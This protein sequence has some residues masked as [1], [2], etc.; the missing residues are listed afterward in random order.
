VLGS[1]PGPQNLRS[2]ARMQPGHV[3][4]LSIGGGRFPVALPVIY[5]LRSPVLAEHL[6]GRDEPDG[7]R[8]ELM[9][10]FGEPSS[11]DLDIEEVRAALGYDEAWWPQGLQYP[12]EEQQQALLDK[13]GSIA[14][15][16]AGSLDESEPVPSG[17]GP[18]AEELLLGGVFTGP[19]EQPPRARERQTE[20]DPDRS[21]R[22]YMA[23]EQTVAK[24]EAHIGPSFRKGTPGIN[25]DGCW[26]VSDQFH[27]AE[28]KSI[29]SR[30]EV[31]QLQKGVGQILHNRFKAQRHGIAVQ[32][33]L[34]A[35]KEPANSGLW[36]DLCE[37][38]GIVFSWPARFAADL[39]PGTT[40]D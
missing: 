35:E 23:H 38:S 27:I 4:L 36:R 15:F 28:V 30:N 22:G 34:V 10:F 33:Y 8:Y 9:F 39:P 40:P 6:W 2:W 25:H 32:G 3:G 20:Y 29:T 7:H 13:F 19:P 24:L 16:V 17:A 14:A 37:K 26:K 5:K 31:G 21:G 11:V 1:K 18:T 12:A